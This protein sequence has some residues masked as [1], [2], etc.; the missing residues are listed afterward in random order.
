MSEHGA[1]DWGSA[2][3]CTALA[4]HFFRPDVAQ[5]PVLFFV[6][7]DLLAALHPSGRRDA[8]V[9]CLGRAVRSG[10]AGPEPRGYFDGFE[11]RGRQWK[12]RGADGAP[13]FLHLLALCVLAATRMGTGSVAATNYRH[14]LCALLEL[15]DAHMPAGFRDSLYYLWETLTWWLDVHLGGALGLSTIVE[16]KHY[17]HIGYPI[18]QTLFRSADSLKLDDFFR[19][20]ALRPG[21]ALDEDVLAAHFRAWAPGRGLSAGALRMV[22]EEQFGAT[23]ARILG[24]FARTWDGTASRAGNERRAVLRVVISAYPRVSVSLMAEQPD[25]FPTRLQGPFAGRTV[26]AMA[27]DGVFTLSGSV[28]GRMLLRG[29]VLGSGDARLVLAGGEV[30][31]LQLDPELGGWAT[32]SSIEPGVRHWLLVS[33]SQSDDVLAQIGRC[34]Q[35]RGVETDAPGALRGWT[36]VRNVVFD[37]AAALSGVLSSQRPT[38]RHRLT[39]RGGLPLRATSSYLAGGA[40]DLWLPVAPND[41]PALTPLLDGDRLDVRG[42]QVRLADVIDASDSSTHVVSWAGTTRRFT[43][44]ASAVR[45]PPPTQVPAHGV[46]VDTDGKVTAHE[47]PTIDPSLDVRIQGAVVEGPA[48]RPRPAPVLLH[49]GAQRAWLLGCHPGQVDEVQP[50]RTPAWLTRAGLTD[51][52]YEARA[53]FDVAWLVQRWTLAPALRIRAVLDEMPSEDVG[54][55]AE[56]VALW[57]RLLL[58]ATLIV[59]DDGAPE[60]LDLYR[61][62]ADRISDDAGV[63]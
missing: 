34:A 1:S 45:S 33:P 32:T 5:L 41:E 28:E 46:Q 36:I 38:N 40:P 39:L 59:R 6:D 51:R 56:A 18:S 62:L 2:E 19:W 13:P 17:T 60:R 54:E 44:V 30:H 42:E 58:N 24:G 16:D 43:T 7:E 47:P 48:V 35:E 26:T 37:D 53:A 55:S 10:L 61:V 21:E 23:I 49:R 4:E 12:L 63:A 8:A 9:A 3:W 57:A 15:D 14:H 22:S 20:I 25:G 29:L 31:V 11:R 52:L 50:P 27:Q